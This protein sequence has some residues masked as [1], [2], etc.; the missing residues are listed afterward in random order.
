MGSGFSGLVFGVVFGIGGEVVEEF[1]GVVV[2][3][4]SGVVVELV[5]FV[6]FG[7][8][9]GGGGGLGSTFLALLV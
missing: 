4:A 6:V 7:P 5:S 8:S 9:P 2:L 3:I 1:V